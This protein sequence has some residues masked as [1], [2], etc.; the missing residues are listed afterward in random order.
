[1][2]D[3]FLLRVPQKFMQ[4]GESKNKDFSDVKKMW[5]PCI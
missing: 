5:N 3:L 4:R 1:M 2:L